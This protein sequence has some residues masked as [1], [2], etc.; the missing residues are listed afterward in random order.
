MKNMNFQ[1]ELE[2]I[3][4]LFSNHK[5]I[6]INVQGPLWSAPWPKISQIVNWRKFDVDL[7]LAIAYPKR[8]I[9]NTTELDKAI[10]YLSYTIKSCL[11]SKQ[12]YSEI[13]HLIITTVHQKSD[14]KST[15]KE[16][17]DA[18][19]SKLEIQTSN[20]VTFTRLAES[21]L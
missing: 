5:P 16:D 21:K 14:M 17:P 10:D 9:S 20:K 4:D 19:G 12:K 6:I 15:K 7:H 8:A 3:S 2:N 11:T 18:P 13:S 1:F